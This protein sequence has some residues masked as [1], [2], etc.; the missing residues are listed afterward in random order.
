TVVAGVVTR[1]VQDSSSHINLKSKERGTPDMVLRDAGPDS[2]ELRAFVDK[3]VHLVVKADGFTLTATTAEIVRKKAAERASR[4]W[5]SLPVERETRLLGTT[6]M[7]PR[8]AA[9]CLDL[10]RRYGSK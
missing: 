10:A 6:E 7:C 2:A 4:P 9:D 5:V 1:A 8:A 3:P